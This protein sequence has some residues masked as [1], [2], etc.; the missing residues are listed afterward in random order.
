MADTD[1]SDTKRRPAPIVPGKSV[2]GRTLMLLVGIMTFLCCVTFGA[3][4]L[5]QKSAIG[6][7]ADVGR[8]L[9]IQIRTIA[10]EDMQSNLRLAVSIAEA[11]PGVARARALS[12]AESE[13]LIAPWLGEV[14]LSELDIPRLVVV[15][16]DD[17]AGVDIDSFRK[18]LSAIAGAELETLDGWRAQLNAMAG[19][20]VAS[21]LLILGLIVFA[22]VLAI[23][24][25]TRGAMASNREIV[26]VLHF[27]GASNEFVAGEFQGRFFRIGLRG[28]LGGG[29]CALLFFMGIGSLSGT[30]LPEGSTAQ[31]SVLFGRFALGWDGI[32][33]IIVI[34]LLISALTALTSRFTVQRF[35]SQLS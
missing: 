19:T 9:T 17:P 33:G 27:I 31:L 4:V 23:V 22:T 21:G 32:L 34:G 35:L 10:G 13:A 18:N 7:S 30:L 3:V 14:D 26:D 24:F 1:T 6:W 11:T 28:G 12:D 2:A 15:E 16:L 8:E 20:V 5:V 25:A 29:V